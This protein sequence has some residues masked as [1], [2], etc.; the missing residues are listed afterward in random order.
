MVLVP[1]QKQ[2]GGAVDNNV[3]PT[4]NNKNE[5][6]TNKNEH[7]TT[8]ITTQQSSSL[9]RSNQQYDPSLVNGRRSNTTPVY[10]T[11]P[12]E[13]TTSA[14]QLFDS[15]TLAEANDALLT[16]VAP[17]QG[18]GEMTSEYPF[19]QQIDASVRGEMGVGLDEL[20]NPAKVCIVMVVLV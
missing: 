1:H 2:S 10:S 13:P 6:P 12:T 8:T 7:Y 11:Q 3:H 20:L 19:V 5:N 14:G 15:S 18:E 9:F 16:G 4:S 17:M